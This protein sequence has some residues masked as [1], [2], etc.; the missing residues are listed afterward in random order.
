[1]N[2]SIQTILERL[3]AAFWIVAMWTV[4]YLVAPVLFATLPERALAGEVAGILFAGIAYIGMGAGLVLLISL[5]KRLSRPL[6]DRGMQ[7]LLAML[8]LVLTGMVLQGQM[9]GLKELG[10]EQGG[11]VAERFALFHKLSSSLYMLNSLLGLYLLIRLNRG[12]D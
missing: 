12:A 8:V 2:Q 4:G 9:A 5:F 6:R 11:A 10:L 7:V 3:F 1:M